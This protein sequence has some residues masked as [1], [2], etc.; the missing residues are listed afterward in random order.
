MFMK[1]TVVWLR[2]HCLDEGYASSLPD[3]AGPE[4][5]LPLQYLC[6][7]V[8]DLVITRIYWFAA[9]LEPCAQDYVSNTTALLVLWMTSMNLFNIDFNMHIWYVCLI[10]EHWKW[11][12]QHVR[13]WWVATSTS[14]D[15]IF[16]CITIL[17]DFR[18]FWFWIW[19]CKYLLTFFSPL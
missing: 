15:R 8:L 2:I 1:F 11:L 6:A 17:T 7:R 10:T 3:C 13:V 19:T 14:S 9:L 4:N 12:L 16:T 5:K 18:S